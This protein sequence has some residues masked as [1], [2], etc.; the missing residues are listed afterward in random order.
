MTL[1]VDA[2]VVVAALT[3]GG[4][5]GAWALG[6]LASGA[7]A[8]HLLPVEVAGVLR[9]AERNQRFSA[10]AVAL[11]HASQLDLPIELHPYEPFAGRIWALRHAVTPYDAWYVALAETLGAPLATLD[12]RLAG[13][14]GPTCR[15]LLD[16]TP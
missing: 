15:F 8:P 4:E 10:E 3:D 2:S 9:R 5:T 6:L 7:A 14:P 1:V 11:A 16:P 12:G 13:A